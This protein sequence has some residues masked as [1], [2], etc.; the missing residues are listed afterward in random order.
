MAMQRPPIRI[1]CEG[2]GHPTH[3]IGAPLLA[4]APSGTICTMCGSPV[5]VDRYGIAS[6]HQ[7][8]DILAM[9]D[10]GDFR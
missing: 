9:I 8:D 1:R 2:S 6:A 3:A 5:A 7:R 4:G 10:R